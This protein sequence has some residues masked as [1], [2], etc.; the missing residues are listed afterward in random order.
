MEVAC[1]V[2]TKNI[3]E[4]NCS[5]FDSVRMWVVKLLASK[6]ATD[7]NPYTRAEGFSYDL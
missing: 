7:E 2:L 6:V 1:V 5:T 4:E 3:F